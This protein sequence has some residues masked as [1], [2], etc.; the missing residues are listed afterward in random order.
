MDNPV[1]EVA[2]RKRSTPYSFCVNICHEGRTLTVYK[3]AS[4][5]YAR[6]SYWQS[7]GTLRFLCVT[8]TIELV[9]LLA[10]EPHGGFITEIEGGNVKSLHVPK[11]ECVKWIEGSWAGNLYE[12]VLATIPGMPEPLIP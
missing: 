3:G 7:V 4:A 2:L 1:T 5:M 9:A 6:G 10:K 11:G 12:K 8:G